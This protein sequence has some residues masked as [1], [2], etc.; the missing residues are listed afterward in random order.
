MVNTDSTPRELRAEAF[1]ALGAAE[2]YPTQSATRLAHLTAANAFAALALTAPS[3]YIA[4]EL[5]VSHGTADSPGSQSPKVPGP[6]PAPTSRTRAP[7][8]P[9][10]PATTPK[11]THTA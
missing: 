11:E 7:R 5:K 3:S 6:D 10:K 2:R 9:S 4:G 8:K 1:K